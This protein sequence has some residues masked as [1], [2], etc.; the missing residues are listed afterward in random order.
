MI[1]TFVALSN[2]FTCKLLL[3]AAVSTGASDYEQLAFAVGGKWMRVRRSQILAA[4][5]A[6]RSMVQ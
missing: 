1:I 4:S 2:V 6:Q 3:R 5:R